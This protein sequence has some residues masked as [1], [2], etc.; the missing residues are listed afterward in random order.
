MCGIESFCMTPG[1][2]TELNHV[3]F[4]LARFTGV[5]EEDFD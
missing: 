1:P 2:L 3:G 5:A 4:S